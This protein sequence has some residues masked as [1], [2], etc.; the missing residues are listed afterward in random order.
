MIKNYI[1]VSSALRQSV[2]Q[3]Y[4]H[5]VTRS[6]G[7]AVRAYIER[8]LQADVA[9]SDEHKESE[10]AI[11]FTH[12]GMM[13]FSCADEIVAK[14]L[15]NNGNGPHQFVFSGLN[16]AHVEAI[17]AVLE[18]LGMALKPKETGTQTYVAEAVH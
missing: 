13:D 10:V 3:T 8:A 18:R 6:T 5:L 12:V 7:A 9:A 2:S 14:L 17:D 16:E 15:Q 11:D 1:D 4:S